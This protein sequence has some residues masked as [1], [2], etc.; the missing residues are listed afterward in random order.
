M[1][2]SIKIAQNPRAFGLSEQAGREARLIVTD[3]SHHAYVAIE[4]MKRV[5]GMSELPPLT[6]SQPLFLRGLEALGRDLPTQ[7]ADN[8]LVAFVSIAATLITSM[9]QEI[10]PNL[11]FGCAR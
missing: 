8:L 11:L 3:E 9:L 1:A 6:Q 4:L 10:P 2:G 7:F 5:P